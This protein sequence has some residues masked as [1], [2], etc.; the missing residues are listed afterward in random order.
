MWGSVR[1]MTSDQIQEGKE[2]YPDDIDEVP[3]EPADLNRAVVVPRNRPPPSPPEHPQYD[4][5][6]DHHVK[7][8]QS[9]HHEVQR[10]KELGVPDVLLLE[11]EPRAGNMVLQELPIVLDAL[12][13]EKRR[14]EHHGGDEIDE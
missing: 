11:L 2:K 14:T 8:V 13:A 9:R 7:R 4:A 12:D 6:A 1:S 3:V 5:H 10:E